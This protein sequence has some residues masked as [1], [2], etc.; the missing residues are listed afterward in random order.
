MGL[1][2]TCL[3]LSS[4]VAKYL[5]SILIALPQSTVLFA[6][7][8]RVLSICSKVGDGLCSKVGDGLNADVILS[9]IADI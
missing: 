3:A 4:K 5:L 9:V 8:T 2:K 1:K 7:V 6:K